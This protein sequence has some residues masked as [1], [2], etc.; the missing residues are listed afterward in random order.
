M[1]LFSLLRKKIAESDKLW[2][3]STVS[4][5]IIYDDMHYTVLPN[6]TLRKS[7]LAQVSYWYILIVWLY[8]LFVRKRRDKWRDPNGHSFYLSSSFVQPQRDF[9]IQIK[10]KVCFLEQNHWESPREKDKSQQNPWVFTRNH[11][12]EKQYW[13]VFE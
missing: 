1:S 2:A 3:G 7:I 8:V 13:P 5:Q 6:K 9:F 4:Y 10:N 12:G 11:T